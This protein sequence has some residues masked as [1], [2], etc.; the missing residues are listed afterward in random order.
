MSATGYVELPILGW[1][2]GDL[3]AKSQGG[4]LGWTYRDDAAMA[5]FGRPLEDPLVEKLLI[6]ALLRINREIANE[7]QAKLAVGALRK[8]MAYGDK[9][10]ANRQTLDLLRDGAKDNPVGPGVNISLDGGDRPD[11]AADLDVNG[12]MVNNILDQLGMHR[13]AAKSAVEVDDVDDLRALL[14]PIIGDG[15]RVVRVN[16]FLVRLALRQPDTATAF[17]VYRRNNFHI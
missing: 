4:G 15:Q 11:A 13:Q 5:V 10:T 14:V 8:T 3:K 2:C 7:A 16:R 1:L 6:E 12:T 9:L 17:N